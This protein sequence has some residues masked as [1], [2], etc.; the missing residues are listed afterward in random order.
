MKHKIA[1]NVA[2]WVSQR[3]SFFGALVPP[4]L[5]PLSGNPGCQT[6]NWNTYVEKKMS[7]F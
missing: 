2:Q 5:D 1:Q 4:A 7:N 6:Q 3:I